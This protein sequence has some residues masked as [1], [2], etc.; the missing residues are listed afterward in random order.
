MGWGGVYPMKPYAL[1]FAGQGAQTPGMGLSVLTESPSL[2]AYFDQLQAAVP[3]SLTEV[4]KGDDGRLNQTRY[5]QP[6]LAV[7][8]LLLYQQLKPFLPKQA[9]AIAGFSLGEITA[10]VASGILDTSSMLSLLNVRAE[11]MEQA[12]L[13][14][15]GKMAA[16]IGASDEQLGQLLASVQEEGVL[17]IVNYN[18]PG[19]RVL[20]GTVKAIDKAVSIASQF[21]ARR[22]IPLAVSGA[23][24]S[25]LMQSAQFPLA[26]LLKTLTIHEPF[27]PHYFN[28]TGQIG[29][30]ETISDLLIEQ[31]VSPVLFE[32]TLLNMA[33]AGIQTFIEIGPGSVLSGFVKK[34]LPDAQVMSYNGIKDRDAVKELWK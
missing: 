30:Q 19:Q 32:T 5:T 9:S 27:I 2:Q 3:F 24:H 16:F 18:C 21:G 31:V 4:L 28:K 26:T 23:F 13:A 10:L 25:S 12:S 17:E 22:A 20:S 29:H 7:T 34:T 14:Q 11:A 33:K 8:S 15:P 1:L 6:S